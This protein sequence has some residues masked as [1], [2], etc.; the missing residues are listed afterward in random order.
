MDKRGRKT[1]APPDFRI[2]GGGVQREVRILPIVVEGEILPGMPL[3]AT[4]LAAM[5][6]SRLHL[7]DGDILVVKHKVVSKSEGAMVALAEI[8]PSAA[9]RSWGWRGRARAR[10]GDLV[11]F[12]D[13]ATCTDALGETSPFSVR[14]SL[15]DGRFVSGCCRRAGG[16]AGEEPEAAPPPPPSTVPT[17]APAL[18]AWISSLVT[19]V[20][21]IKAC[22]QEA[23]RAEAVV[24][25]AVLPDKSAHLVLRL[26][27]S[28]FA[29][30]ELPPGRGPA[31]VSLRPRDAPTTPEE[32]AAVLTLLRMGPPVSEPCFRPQPV[33]DD[34]GRRLGWVAIK[35]C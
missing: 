20:P 8:R 2:V 24:F 29:D 34:E 17:P 3:S 11:A 9:S 5:R 15:P 6:G 27:G 19:F 14:A 12:V 10:G 7:E 22:V 13:D 26:A 21:A 28:R 23:S 35:G 25:A 33:E 32:N 4:L 1:S 18:G 16:E 31:R 30:C